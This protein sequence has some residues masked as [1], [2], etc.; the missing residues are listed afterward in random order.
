MAKKTKTVARSAVDGKFVTKKFADTH[1][2]TTV[3]ER[4][5][6]KKKGK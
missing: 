5:P 2:R 4:I 6:S 1:K 3:V